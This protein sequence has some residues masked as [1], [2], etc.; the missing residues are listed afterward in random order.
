MPAILRINTEVA[1]AQ[2]SPGCAVAVMRIAVC[3][4]SLSADRPSEENRSRTLVAQPRAAMIRSISA[5]GQRLFQ[6]D[7]KNPRGSR[8]AL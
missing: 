5:F 7:A 3:N 6:V 4:R 8:A 1:R 2:S